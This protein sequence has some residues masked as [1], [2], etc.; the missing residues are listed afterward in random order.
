MHPEYLG[1]QD[2]FYVGHI[3]GVGPIYQQTF[4]DTHSKVAICQL[5]TGKNAL[6]AAHHLDTN[7]VPI[8]EEH[9]I[10]LLKILNDRGTE[11]NGNP[12]THEYQLVLALS[13]I[14][15]SRT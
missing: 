4:I 10:P 7:V 6:T 1:A 13:D 5:Y 14:D 2:A 11:S 12:E 3:K 8:F 15:H 9:Q